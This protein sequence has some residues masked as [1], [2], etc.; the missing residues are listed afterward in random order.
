M[1]PVVLPASLRGRYINMSIPSY[2]VPRSSVTDC[3]SAPLDCHSV[4]KRG[5]E[6][7]SFRPS[8]ASDAVPL[9]AVAVRGVSG[10]SIIG[11]CVGSGARDV[12]GDQAFP[13]SPSLVTIA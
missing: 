11:G 8:M 4:W 13:I 3:G 10:L 1:L 5:P 6:G 12:F 9:V 7:E 2:E